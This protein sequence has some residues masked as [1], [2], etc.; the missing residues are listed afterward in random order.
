MKSYAFLTG[1]FL[2]LTQLAT[3]QLVGPVEVREYSD[4]DFICQVEFADF[5]DD[6]LQEIIAITQNE[7]IVYYNQGNFDFIPEVLFVSDDS[8]VSLLK[9]NID[10]DQEAEFLLNTVENDLQLFTVNGDSLELS[11]PFELMDQGLEV[12]SSFQLTKGFV[13]EDDFEDL[14]IYGSATTVFLNQGNGSFE[15]SQSL[16]QPAT[17]LGLGNLDSS[18]GDDLCFSNDDGLFVVMNQIASFETPQLVK[19]AS[20]WNTD[21]QGGETNACLDIGSINFNTGDILLK[22]W[23]AD[24]DDDILYGNEN[25]SYYLNIWYDENT[26]HEERS[27]ELF[28]S[29]IEN[30]ALFDLNTVDST[31]VES[32]SLRY[33]KFNDFTYDN[34]EGEKRIYYTTEG[35]ESGGV[36]ASVK[37]LFYSISGPE[38]D[39]LIF[40]I[41]EV[42]GQPHLKDLDNDGNLDLIIISPNGTSGILSNFDG[43]S[44][45]ESPEESFHVLGKENFTCDHLFSFDVDADGSEEPLILET[46]DLRYRLI[47]VSDI[48]SAQDSPLIVLEWYRKTD[49]VIDIRAGDLN[50]DGN[51]DLVILSE[52]ILPLNEQDLNLSI[53]WNSGGDFTEPEEIF[54]N[55]DFRTESGPSFKFADLN[56]DE[57]VDLILNTYSVEGSGIFTYS[58]GETS[59]EFYSNDGNGQLSL[60][61]LFEYSSYL[62]S[63]DFLDMNQDGEREIVFYRNSAICRGELN[64]GDVE[65][66]WSVNSANK[67]AHLNFGDFNSDGVTDIFYRYKRRSFNPLGKTGTGILLFDSNLEVT[68]HIDFEDTKGDMSEQVYF[69]N[70][71]LPDI[72]DQNRIYFNEAGEIG[73][74]EEWNDLPFDHIK[75][76]KTGKF[77]NPDQSGVMAEVDSGEDHSVQIWFDLSALQS[78]IHISV[79]EDE[80]GNGERD[81]TEQGIGGM[82]LSFANTNQDQAGMA[83][84]NSS[85]SI[86][87]YVLALDSLELELLFDA[88]VWA[89]T[90]ANSPQTVS[91]FNAPELVEFG[92]MQEGLG[93]TENEELS[94]D[95]NDSASINAFANAK[96]DGDLE[97]IETNGITD[98]NYVFVEDNYQYAWAFTNTTGA[99]I[100]SIDFTGELPGELD[101]TTFVPLESSEDGGTVI[102]STFGSLRLDVSYENLELP[103]QETD[104]EGSLLT[105]SYAIRASG[106]TPGNTEMIN[107]VKATLIGGN[108]VISNET[109]NLVYTCE[110][111]G[112]TVNLGVKQ[113]CSPGTAGFD[114]LNNQPVAEFGFFLD[115]EEI[116]LMELEVISSNDSA[117]VYGT[118]IYAS[119]QTIALTGTNEF[120]CAIDLTETVEA[121]SSYQINISSESPFQV[122]FQDS[123]MLYAEDELPFE[124][125]WLSS[126][127]NSAVIEPESIGDSLLVCCHNWMDRIYYAYPINDNTLCRDTSQ[128]VVT[129]DA[130]GP[131]DD[132]FIQPYPSGEGLQCVCDNDSIYWYFEEELIEV[133]NGGVLSNPPFEG[134][135][136]CQVFFDGCDHFT[137]TYSWTPTSAY[138][139]AKPEFSLYPSPTSNFIHVQL[140][141]ENLISQVRIIDNLGKLQEVT[142]EDPSNPHITIDI[143][144][145]AQGVYHLQIEFDDGW[146]QSQPFVIAR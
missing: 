49:E 61:N 86:S 71:S 34:F 79:F 109:T 32:N 54:E 89:L 59:V 116:D 69:D 133:T 90:T 75:K 134:S 126:T 29:F 82:A 87:F 125:Q 110:L 128:Q 37:N 91:A 38:P 66:P 119:P 53:S 129:F 13:D 118:T 77:G 73:E 46:S 85:G 27:S 92:L 122:C 63:W 74:G 98:N 104:E 120:G 36:L 50:A 1:F 20:E 42:K 97:L 24:G 88:E 103:D 80:N 52:G 141:R 43:L 117:T 137:E 78:E 108:E 45:L 64:T 56:D 21:C 6:G 101:W 67:F 51:M 39:T 130:S 31:M 84:T 83:F 144:H 57:V 70:D 76:F 25:Q 4:H 55:V 47:D 139:A 23:D 113:P 60:T 19:E 72:I 81:E 17:F 9:I 14:L 143:R 3:A 15:A 48:Q 22:D 35:F 33:E 121:D 135:Y 99:D 140:K 100:N 94:E 95:P 11:G 41:A 96:N 44:D 142:I 28:L 115:G 136:Q 123:I 16:P 146:H 131:N 2:T 18:G 107:S 93:L 145:L 127:V 40:N 30:Q 26:H 132:G 105:Y 7:L 62:S 106:D 138:E 5:N 112:E 68:E 111:F 8:I 58:S 12:P 124:I 102:T 10:N 65:F 114:V